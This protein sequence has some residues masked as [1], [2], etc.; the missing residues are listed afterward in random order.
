MLS[1]VGE[2]FA[3][4]MDGTNQSALG[5]LPTQR[6]N[7]RW[8]FK[9][10][11]EILFAEQ[12]PLPALRAT[13]TGCVCK[14]PVEQMC[15]SHLISPHPTRRGE[16]HLGVL[17]TGGVVGTADVVVEVRLRSPGDERRGAELNRVAISRAVSCPEKLRPQVTLNHPT[18]DEGCNVIAALSP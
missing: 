5:M 16:G 12:H 17:V 8:S 11:R 9:V 10:S 15:I 13:K 3:Q 18:R 4:V 6:A 14:E 2:G 7:K 1:E